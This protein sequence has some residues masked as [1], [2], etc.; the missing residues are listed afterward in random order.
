[1]K[2]TPFLFIK[3][4]EYESTFGINNKE[5]PGVPNATLYN[6]SAMNKGLKEMEELKKNIEDFYLEEK[7]R[8]ELFWNIFQKKF[9]KSTF[10]EDTPEIISEIK[11]VSEKQKK[12]NI[13]KNNEKK[14]KYSP[15]ISD[16]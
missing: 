11:Y 1:M 9:Y 6:F 8:D 3:P 12:K 15:R 13:K 10:K 14:K 7:K 5:G 2:M 16:R 4:S